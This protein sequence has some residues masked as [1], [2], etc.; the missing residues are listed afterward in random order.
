MQ[1]MPQSNTPQCAQGQPGHCCSSKQMTKRKGCIT[2]SLVNHDDHAG[3]TNQYLISSACAYR[4]AGACVAGQHSDD[5]HLTASCMSEGAGIM[6]TV[7]SHS[8]SN[9]SRTRLGLSYGLPA[10]LRLACHAFFMAR[11]P[12]MMASDDP[13]VAV[14]VPSPPLSVSPWYRLVSMVTHL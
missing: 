3:G 10:A 11:P 5:M 14:P 4:E 2:F 8:R 1:T 6:H 9:E 12:S 13:I 7:I